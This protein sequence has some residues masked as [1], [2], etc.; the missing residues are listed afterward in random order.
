MLVS[1]LQSNFLIVTEY[2]RSS[3]F[4]ALLVDSGLRLARDN[5][6]VEMQTAT[7]WLNQAESFITFMI[8][9]GPV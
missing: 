3:E 9:H 7:F 6:K 2:R 8:D 4:I 1:V 5:D